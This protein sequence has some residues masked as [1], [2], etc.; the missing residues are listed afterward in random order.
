MLAEIKTLVIRATTPPIAAPIT[1][2]EETTFPAAE[3]TGY[4]VVDVQTETE[5]VS[6]R[7][8]VK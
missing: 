4:Y 1:N 3:L 2:Q 7:Y 5:K 8:V 6:L